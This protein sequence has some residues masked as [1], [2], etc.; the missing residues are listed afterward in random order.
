MAPRKKFHMVDAIHKLRS[1]P[2]PKE[3]RSVATMDK[4]TTQELQG[5]I[6]VEATQLN[7]CRTKCLGFLLDQIFSDFTTAISV[8]SPADLV[9]PRN[10]ISRYHPQ[11]T[12]RY[13]SNNSV[14]L[15][16]KDARGW[17]W[18]LPEDA[19]LPLDED[20]KGG[21]QE[22]HVS[23]FFNA[24]ASALKP[25]I[26]KQTDALKEQHWLGS[27]STRRIPGKVDGAGTY[28]RKPDLILIETGIWTFSCE[29]DVFSSKL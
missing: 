17:N 14:P 21:W 16:D 5:A 29:L 20:D 15:Y 6:I 9:V 13:P 28:H 26:A 23:A 3:G 25:A 19:T 10:V 24:V 7:S 1:Y 27:Y 2:V 8:P 18:P 11:I 4:I 22:N 12:Q